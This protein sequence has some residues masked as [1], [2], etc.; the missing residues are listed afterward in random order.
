MMNRATEQRKVNPVCKKYRV[1]RTFHFHPSNTLII[2]ELYSQ[3]LAVHLEMNH[4][5]KTVTH[6][7]KLKQTM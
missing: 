5:Y 2:F 6:D 4:Y 1:S 7:N 3:G